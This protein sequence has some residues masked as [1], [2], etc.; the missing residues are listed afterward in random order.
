MSCVP[1]IV[2][3]LTEIS[4]ADHQFDVIVIA[5]TSDTLSENAS[6]ALSLGDTYF[7]NSNISSWK[8]WYCLDN[9]KSRFIWADTVRGKG[10]IYRM[11]DQ[12]GND[13]PY[14][15]KNVQFKYR[16]LNYENGEWNIIQTSDWVY[17]FTYRDDEAWTIEDY[18]VVRPVNC[19]GNII[20]GKPDHTYS[21][22]PRAIPYIVFSN[23]LKTNAC[24]KN[25]IEAPQTSSENMSNIRTNHIV[26]GNGAHNNTVGRGCFEIYTSGSCYN[27]KFDTAVNHVYLGSKC[28]T[29]S[30]GTHTQKVYL[31]ENC[32][33]NSFEHYCNT[34]ESTIKFGDSCHYNT[35]GRCSKD[36]VFGTSC[37]HNTLEDS[38][39]SI[40]L[41]DNCDYNFFGAHVQNV[42]LDAESKYKRYM[43]GIDG[44]VVSKINELLETSVN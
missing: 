10:V 2:I 30:F 24:Y 13:C 16:Y 18:S 15:F 17:T 5:L 21:G 28:H 44:D 27:N 32:M 42:T 9:D 11:I 12:S 29:N 38:D 41:N 26:F 19:F 40:T 25:Y 3:P 31:G 22:A 23:N 14:D 8:L 33:A 34:D 20:K 1:L 39:Y 6:A 36:L 37:S 4:V 35:V 43:R 7:K